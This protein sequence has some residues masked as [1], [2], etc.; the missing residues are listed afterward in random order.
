MKTYDEVLNTIF[1]YE[2]FGSTP[3]LSAISA[4]LEKFDNPQDKIKTVHIAGTNGKGSTANYIAEGLKAAGYKTGLFTSPFIYRFNER[5]QIDNVPISDDI[6]AKI[7]EKVINE[8][9]NL[10]KE[11]Y[12]IKQ[13]ELVTAIGFV[14]FYAEN[15]DYAVIECGMGGLNDSTNIIKNPECSV[16]CTIS[17]DHMNILGNTVLEIAEKKSGIIKNSPVFYYPCGESDKVIQN[18]AKEMNVTAVSPDFNGITEKNITPCGNSFVYKNKKIKTSMAGEHQIYNAALAYE[19]M[20]FLNLSQKAIL[21]GIEKA[22]V[23][24]RFEKLAENI[25]ADGAHNREGALSLVNS[26]K[27]AD[28]KNPVY[29][30]SVGRDKDFSEIA[31]IISE[32]AE[33]I[34]LTAYN[35][36]RAVDTDSLKKYINKNVKITVAE[37]LD[38][39]FEM[40]NCEKNYIFCGSLYQISEIKIRCNHFG[41]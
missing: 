19:I 37:N 40:L 28:I 35:K 32:N 8:A 2:R 33:E 18:K 10:K 29:V 20:E 17:L 13:F 36:E 3:N 31:K 4:L 5:F 11:G 7:G 12:F 27:K 14:Y 21:E 30:L 38:K 39:V 16:I 9:E 23:P 22:Y 25:F 15:C 41:I 26:V 24:G 1:S 6:L 34:I